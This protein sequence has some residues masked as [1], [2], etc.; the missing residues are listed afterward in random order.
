MS[1]TSDPLPVLATAQAL[2]DFT[3]P[4]VS[5]ELAGLAAQARIVD[6]IG[7][8]GCSEADD[9]KIRAAARHAVIIKS[10]NMSLGVNL[11]AKLVREAAKALPGYDVEILEMHHSRKV[12]A[13]SG[14]AL[15]L[16]RGGGAGTRHLAGR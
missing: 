7:T 13:P 3:I 6:V 8:T 4:R 12:D 14:T 1:L 5:V 9:A 11:L 16:G 10:G 15:M 2:I